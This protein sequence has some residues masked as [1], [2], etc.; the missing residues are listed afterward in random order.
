MAWEHQQERERKVLALERAG[1]LSMGTG[2]GGVIRVMHTVGTSGEGQYG[3][4]LILSVENNAG[5]QVS[6]PI[7]PAWENTVEQFIGA[8]RHHAEEV[9]RINQERQHVAADSANTRARDL[10]PEG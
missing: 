3:S 10:R 5:E 9:V 7:S 1:G 2:L 4:Y 8:L 6:I